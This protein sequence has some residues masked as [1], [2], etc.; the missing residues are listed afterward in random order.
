MPKNSLWVSWTLDFDHLHK[1]EVGDVRVVFQVEED[2]PG[3]DVA[4]DHP[5]RVGFVEGRG[6]PPDDRRGGGQRERAVG[7]AVLERAAL[8]VAHDEEQLLAVLAVIVY[9]DDGRVLERGDRLGLAPEALAVV[10]ILPEVEGS[11]LTATWRSKT[12]SWPR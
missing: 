1:A 5:H 2:V 4:V 8:H 10:G 7:Q 11:T 6:D 9:R 12:S 3:L